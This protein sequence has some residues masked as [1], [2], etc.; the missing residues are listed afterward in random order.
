MTVLAILFIIAAA[1]IALFILYKLILGNDGV[2]MKVIW[3]LF[4]VGFCVGFYFLYVYLFTS[5]STVVSSVYLK[6]STP[7]VIDAKTFVSPNSP[8]SA[9]GVWIY[10]NSWNSTGNKTVFK[11]SGNEVSLYFDPTTP[12]L[13]C[14]VQSGCST[15]EKQTETILITKNFPLQKWTYVVISLN[16]A[17]IDAFLDG[18]LIASHKMN[19]AS[20]SIA[21]GTTSWSINMGTGFDAYAYNLIRYTH[22]MTPSEA[23]QTYYS[24]APTSNGLGLFNGMNINLAIVTNN[25]ACDS[26]II[27]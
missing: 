18:K 9:F 4:L 10:V 21:C 16:G 6:G 12:S 19:N 15:N 24:T 14:N 22:A 5:T 17:F 2:T 27:L 23:Y 1:L 3:G 25:D 26:T 8:N 11:T 20:L 13:K 7:T